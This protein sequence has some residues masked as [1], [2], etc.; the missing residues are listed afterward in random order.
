[1]DI[2]QQFD[3]SRNPNVISLVK[4]ADG[5]WKGFMQKNG[6]Y[7]TVRAINPEYCLQ[8]LLTNDGKSS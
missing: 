6:K 4:Q 3:P 1:M 2:G 5:N 8:E 7:L